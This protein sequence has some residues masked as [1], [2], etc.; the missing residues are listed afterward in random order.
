MNFFKIFLIFIACLI[1]VPFAKVHAAESRGAVKRYGQGLPSSRL[2]AGSYRPNQQSDQSRRVGSYGTNQ[3][4]EQLRREVE[5]EARKAAQEA[6]RDFER[7]IRNRGEYI[8]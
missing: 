3:R 1:T 2:P 6:V 7:H 4:I 8:P 5:Q